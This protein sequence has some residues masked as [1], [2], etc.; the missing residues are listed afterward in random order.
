[1][2]ASITTADVLL[3]VCFRGICAVEGRDKEMEEDK[4]NEG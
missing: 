1:M 4:K 3:C 2:R